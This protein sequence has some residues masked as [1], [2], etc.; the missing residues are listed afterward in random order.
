MYPHCSGTHSAVRTDLKLGDLPISA[1]QVLGLNVCVITTWLLCTF[2]LQYFLN[3]R[4]YVSQLSAMERE[5][6]EKM[7][8]REEKAIWPSVSDTSIVDVGRTPR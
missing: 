8:L 1:S 6:L 5:I 7:N 4:G 3:F 2:Y